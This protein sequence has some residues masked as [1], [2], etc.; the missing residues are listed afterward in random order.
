MN[1]GL[2]KILLEGRLE[3]LMDK[4]NIGKETIFYKFFYIRSI[5]K[6]ISNIDWTLKQVFEWKS[7]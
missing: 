2:G 6:R 3:N 4:Y 1:V 7:I 5:R